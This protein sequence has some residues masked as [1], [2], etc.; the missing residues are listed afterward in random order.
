M[1]LKIKSKKSQLSLF[2]FL[3]AFIFLMIGLLYFFMINSAQEKKMKEEEINVEVVKE[4]VNNYLKNNV[5]EALYLIGSQGGYIFE[6]QGGTIKPSAIKTAILKNNDGKQSRVVYQLKEISYGVLNEPPYY[7]CYFVNPDCKFNHENKYAFGYYTPQYVC[8]TTIYKTEFGYYECM[9]EETKASFSVEE[10]LKGFL[11]KKMLEINLKTLEEDYG[12]NIVFKKT[13]KFDIVFAEDNVNVRMQ[14]EITISN[15]QS[16]RVINNFEVKVPVRIL[17]IYSGLIE[18][19]K[20]EY[21]NITFNLSKDYKKYYKFD[22]N[23]LLKKEFVNGLNDYLITITDKNSKVKSQNFVFRFLIKNRAPALDYIEINN[24]INLPYEI[25]PLGFDPD[26]EEVT[27]SIEG[28][29]QN[30]YNYE[31]CEN[32]VTK[33]IED[34][35]CFI[36]HSLP[37][38]TYNFKIII[39]DQT[40]NKDWQ[41]LTI[42]I[43]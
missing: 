14:F 23:I 36:V 11:E 5:E 18:I 28:L 6:N 37:Q 26:E 17:K 27:Y 31:A 29:N 43:P 40:G 21:T 2:I 3:G 20:E 4:F 34:K 42:V 9:G 19:L 22:D 7:P 10:Q 12:Y 33:V 1:I 38:G 39:S 35:R 30:N 15:K 24:P 25:E 8:R 16:S 13:P 32:P 41:D